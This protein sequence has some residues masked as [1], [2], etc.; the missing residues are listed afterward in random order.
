MQPAP[1]PVFVAFPP[2]GTYGRV[3]RCVARVL[4]RRTVL[5][6]SG[7]HPK[8]AEYLHATRVDTHGFGVD[9]CSRVSFDE[10]VWN[11]VQP[12]ALLIMQPRCIPLLKMG[13][14]L[15]RS[16]INWV[17]EASR[18]LTCILEALEPP[19]IPLCLRAPLF[20]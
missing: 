13:E 2:A 4:K 19:H 10:Q 8:L 18:N 9:R 20:R 16:G 11:L 12:M 7:L 5:Q 15:C 14:R 3:L 17:L 1:G 6:D